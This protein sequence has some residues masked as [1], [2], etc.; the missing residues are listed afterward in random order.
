MCDL[1]D[2]WEGRDPPPPGPPPGLRRR[3]REIERTLPGTPAPEAAWRIAFGEASGAIAWADHLRIA[4]AMQRAAAEP[5]P[6]GR[7]RRARRMECR[8][9]G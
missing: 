9:A 3:A 5:A 2:D 6:F 4:T 1:C 7:G 8:A